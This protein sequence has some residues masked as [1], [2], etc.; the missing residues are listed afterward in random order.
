MDKPFRERPVRVDVAES[1]A[2][3]AREQRRPAFG[4]RRD[5]DR[6]GIRATAF[7]VDDEPA[8]WMKGRAME[9]LSLED[10]GGSDGARVKP[11]ATVAGGNPFG[12]AKPRD[13]A[14]YEAR[15]KEER[16]RRAEE[17]R[18][19]KEVRGEGAKD[20]PAAAKPASSA[21]GGSW[22]DS[23]KPPEPRAPRGERGPSQGDRK[24]REPRSDRPQ[25]DAPREQKKPAAE[26]PAAVAGAAK[27][28]EAPK[29]EKK[30][31]M[32][33]LLGETDE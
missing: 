1:R 3:P 29:A 30:V 22:R 31:N 33:D 13:E 26:A 17:R 4:E 20:K 16:E 9:K 23:A 2:P 10:G 19:E 11:A 21:P 18:R 6:G 25:R 32:F 24:P 7:E 14:A 5:R 12:N 8:D 27:K 15:R 28:P